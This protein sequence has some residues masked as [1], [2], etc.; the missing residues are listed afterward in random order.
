[1]SKDYKVNAIILAAGIGTRLRPVT[2]FIPKPLLPVGG[3]P[4]LESIIMKMK[5]AGIAKIAVNTHHLADRIESFIRNSPYSDMVELFHEKEILGTGGPL[6]NAKKL[7]SETD[8]F[9][10]YNGDILSD[11][12]LNRLIDYHV[13]SG[14]LATLVTIQGPENRVLVSPDSINSGTIVDILGKLGKTCPSGNIMTYAGI[15]VFSRD[16]FKYLPGRPVNHSVISSILDAM[17][18]EP[19]SVGAYMPEKISWNDVGTAGKYFELLSAPPKD[20]LRSSPSQSSVKVIQIAEQGSNRKFYRLSYPDSSKVVMLSSYEDQD[21]DRF[22]KI[23]RYFYTNGFGTPEIFSFNKAQYA[24]LVEDLGDETVYEVLKNR[25]KGEVYRKVIDWLVGFQKKSCELGV[26]CRNEINRYF[27]YRGMRW[28]TEYF[29]DNFLK[30]HLDVDDAKCA[31]IQHSFDMLANEALSQPQILIH[32]DFQSQNIMIKDGN[33]RIVDFQGA[34]Q[35]PLAYD[36]MS[37]LKDA[38]VDIPKDL[39]KELEV[40]YYEKLQGTGVNKLI[41]P[42]EQFRKYTVI[43]GLQ[44]NMQALGAFAFL[45]FFKGKKR[46]LDFIPGGVENLIEGIEELESLPDRPFS[47]SKLLEILSGAGKRN[48]PV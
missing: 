14:K 37:L 17:A 2:D 18:D 19:G 38:Y 42:R 46:Y 33:V 13:S 28:E 43:A 7:L 45:S 10:L 21:F 20:E 1:M 24:V 39:R 4:L 26:E 40:Y 9:V 27:D 22:I 3:V 11:L 44:R 25:D 29:T 48:M 12:D 34:R 41:F 6:V 31:T 32:R 15:A 23:G 36:L 47:L 16:M 35:G 30:R 5:E 8:Y